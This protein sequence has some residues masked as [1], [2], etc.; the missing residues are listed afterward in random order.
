MPS[1]GLGLLPHIR[2]L[3]HF[4]R[5]AGWMP[6]AVTRLLT[7][8]DGVHLVGVDEDTALVGGPEEF[9]VHG[10]QSAW[11]LGDRR[12]RFPAGSTLVLPREGA[13]IGDGV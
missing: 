10:R 9:I 6:D 11:L 4:D 1:P 7:P 8:P 13:A 12:R 3:P 2:V 5:M